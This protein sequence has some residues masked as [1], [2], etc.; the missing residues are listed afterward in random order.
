MTPKVYKQKGYLTIS[1]KTKIAGANFL[2][3]SKSANNKDYNNVIACL[4]VETGG[5]SLNDSYS[6]NKGTGYLD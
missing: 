5:L 6:L 4:M 3:V 1:Y 2:T